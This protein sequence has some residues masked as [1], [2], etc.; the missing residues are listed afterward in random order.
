MTQVVPGWMPGLLALLDADGDGLRD[1]RVAGPASFNGLGLIDSIPVETALG[2][3]GGGFGAMQHGFAQLG[4]APGI[5]ASCVARRPTG[6]ASDVV[7]LIPPGL[8]FPAWRLIRVGYGAALAVFLPPGPA[9]E[10]RA[11]DL[12]GDPLA[13]WF[14]VQQ[15]GGQP[16]LSVLAGRRES[17]ATASV[18]AFGAAT[19]YARIALADEDGDGDDDVGFVVHDPVA[20]S[21]VVGLLRNTTI[22]GAGWPGAAGLPSLELGS[23]TAALTL[24]TRGGPAGGAVV[25]AVSAQ[26]APQPWNPNGI[27]I[28]FGT[29]IPLPPSYGLFLV[30]TANGAGTATFPFLAGGQLPALVDIVVYAQA[31]VV[32]PAAAVPG[33]PPGFAL[34]SGRRLVL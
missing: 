33:L 31:A 13:D 24:E 22:Y 7:F 5:A 14:I 9:Y 1:L 27:L 3:P 34:T 2:V 18:H 11:G 17:Y 28:D 23:P 21:G 26:A 30:G 8:T 19:G 15:L 4:A 6:S 12:D 29:L 10:V 32:D 16:R 20:G 25:L